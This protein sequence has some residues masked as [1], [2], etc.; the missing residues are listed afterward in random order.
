[1]KLFGM[2]LIS[3]GSLFSAS[4]YCSGR[5][6]REAALQTI[7]ASLERMEAELSANKTPLP[8]LTC[9]LAEEC[10]GAASRFFRDLEGRLPQIGERSFRE[11]WRDSLA[12]VTELTPSQQDR[13]KELGSALGRYPLDRQLDACTRCRKLLEEDLRASQSAALGDMRLAWGLSASLGLMLWI[14]LV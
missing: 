13:L 4:A 8:V 7:C 6:K 2:L 3:L 9:I 12:E 1:M 10:D 14:L 11:L 5:R